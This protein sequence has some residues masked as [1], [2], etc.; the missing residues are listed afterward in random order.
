MQNVY[1]EEL[2]DRFYREKYGINIGSYNRIVR[3]SLENLYFRG[4]ILSAK[5]LYKKMEECGIELHE[6]SLHRV[7]FAALVAKVPAEPPLLTHHGARTWYMMQP[8]VFDYEDISFMAK[9]FP[10]EM[11]RLYPSLWKGY[12]LVNRQKY[13]PEYISTELFDSEECIFQ[14]DSERPKGKRNAAFAV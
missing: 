10:A 11:M 9:H 8:F 12:I 13:L 5:T 6:N 14:Q 1:N 2:A 4:R 3:Q 7:R